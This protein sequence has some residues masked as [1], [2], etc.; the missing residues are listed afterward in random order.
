MEKEKLEELKVDFS[1]SSLDHQSP[2]EDE[3]ELI[4]AVDDKSNKRLYIINKILKTWETQHSADID[5]RK[6]YAKWLFGVLVI[7]TLAVIGVV[8]GT[9]CQCLVFEEWAFRMFLGIA[10]AQISGTIHVIVKYLFSKDSHVILSDIAKI[11][12]KLNEKQDKRD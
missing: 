10:Y 7:E 9:G 1:D 5:L 8:V 3:N 11:V 2:I 6:R 12:D 4:D